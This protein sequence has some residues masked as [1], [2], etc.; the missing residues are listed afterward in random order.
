METEKL[1][2]GL[3]TGLKSGWNGALWM[4]KILIP[5]SF[6]TMVA[7][8]LGWIAQLDGI[9][10][11]VM[12]FMGLPAMAALPL[13]VGMLTNIYGAI[14]VMITLPF[15]TNTMTLMAIYL[16]IAHNLIQEGV[17]QQASGMNIIVITVIRLVAAILTVCAVA[18]WLPPEAMEKAAAMPSAAPAAFQDAVMLWGISTFW[19]CVKIL[20]III[21]L[22]TLLEVMK[23]LDLIRYLLRFTAPFLRFMGL[24]QTVGFLWLTAMIFGLSYGAA[25]IVEE[26][27][28]GTLDSDALECLHVSVAINHSMVEDPA[29]FLPLGLPAFWLWIPRVITAIL[30]SKLWQLWQKLRPSAFSTT[31]SF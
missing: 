18:I 23:A 9:F 29:L 21:S 16:L 6:A 11:P 2:T 7:A 3:V 25:V 26:V 17:V 10:A 30:F 4:F 20:V 19:M 27:R 1:K 22:L 24:D 5:I 12:N 28:K 13:V 15:D 8:H 14:A 31:G